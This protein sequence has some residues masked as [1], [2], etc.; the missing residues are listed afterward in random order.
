MFDINGGAIS[1]K[2][3]VGTVVIRL[4]VKIVVRGPI[5]LNLGTYMAS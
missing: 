5:Y 1:T 3:I 4:K 2:R